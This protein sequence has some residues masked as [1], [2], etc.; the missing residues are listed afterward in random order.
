LEDILSAIHPFSPLD[1]PQR[2]QDRGIES[3]REFFAE[4]VLLDLVG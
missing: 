1:L 4:L 2:F 3:G